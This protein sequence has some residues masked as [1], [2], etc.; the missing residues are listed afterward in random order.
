MRAPKAAKATQSVSASSECDDFDLRLLDALQHDGALT[1]AELAERIGLSPSQASRRRQRLEERG[2]IRGYHAML[3][4]R[5][6][7]FGV[8][9]FIRVTLA[10]HSPHNSRR[11]R[12]LVSLTPAIREAHTLTGDADYLLKVSVHGLADLST[13]VNDVLLPHESVERVR[14]EIVLE[15]LKETGVLPLSP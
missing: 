10:T 15:T 1:N 12:D 11:F 14:S 2:D 6:L 7:G 13:L 9:V 3:D 8:T 4:A 5:R